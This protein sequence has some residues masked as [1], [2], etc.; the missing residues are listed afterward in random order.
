MAKPQGDKT[1]ETVET[2]EKFLSL[3]NAGHVP[4][5]PNLKKLVECILSGDWDEINKMIHP[6]FAA[7]GATGFGLI[8]D[9]EPITLEQLVHYANGE[10]TLLKVISWAPTDKEVNETLM[11]FLKG[12]L[13]YIAAICYDSEI[14]ERRWRRYFKQELSKQQD[15][16]R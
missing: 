5:C 2:L 12:R 13:S 16:T 10:A 6:M 14:N 9:R 11:S 7:L 8:G 3:V 4:K 15:K 1:S